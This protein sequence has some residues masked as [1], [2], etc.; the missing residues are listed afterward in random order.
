MQ[1]IHDCVLAGRYLV[2]FEYPLTVDKKWLLLGY[3]FLEC[4]QWAPEKYNTLIHIFDKDTLKKVTQLEAPPLFNYHFSNGYC[5]GEEEIVLQ[6]CAYPTDRVQDLF[7]DLARV[8]KLAVDPK[9]EFKCAIIGYFEEMKID[10]PS[11]K[12]TT[13]RNM[14][15]AVE[16]PV[17]SDRLV[18]KNWRYT[19]AVISE[20]P[21]NPN[22]FF[23]GVCRYD[24]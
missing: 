14:N 6:Y 11:K 15:Y 23:N 12:I 22:S 8:P 10:L 18:G 9:T 20:D 13:D 4:V 2:I 24:R 3:S 21:K 16:F 5:N 17:V 1:S 7:N 19:H